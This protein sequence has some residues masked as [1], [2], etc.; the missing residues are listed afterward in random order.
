MTAPVLHE[1]STP[2]A[3]EQ[4][5]MIG[6]WEL[7]FIM[8]P[9]MQANDIP[10]TLDKSIQFNQLDGGEFLAI[11]FDGFGSPENLREHMSMLQD[12]AQ[13]NAIPLENKP[14]FAVDASLLSA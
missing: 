3:F 8:P 9:G 12:Y 11:Q 14:M 5:A 10:G 13:R 6:D 4:A 2:S 1:T 7:H